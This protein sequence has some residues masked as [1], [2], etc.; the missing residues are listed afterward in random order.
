MKSVITVIGADGIG[1]IARVSA[2]LAKHNI[3]IV[4][5]SQT[6]ENNYFL[7]VMLVDMKNADINFSETSASLAKL[8][9]VIG[10]KITMRHEKVF[11][12]MHRI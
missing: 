6:T 10:Q 9:N 3:N 7:M 8:G 11:N 2:F 5:I 12:S 1:I 4:D